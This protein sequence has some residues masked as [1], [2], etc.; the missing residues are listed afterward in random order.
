[1][2]GLID[3]ATARAEIDLAALRG[4][5]QGLAAHVAPAQLMV[6]VKADG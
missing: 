4:N 5:V 2:S 6:V 1:M 3:P